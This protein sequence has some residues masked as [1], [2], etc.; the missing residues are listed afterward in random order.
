MA[1]I[2]YYLDKR[3]TGW[4]KPAPLKFSIR[5][6]SKA[7]LVSTNIRLLPEQWDDVTNKVVNHPKATQ[8]NN[9]LLR[10]YLDVECEVLRL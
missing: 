6:R 2:N 3:A 5:H 9:L 7:V 4:D 1:T 8:L 10:Q